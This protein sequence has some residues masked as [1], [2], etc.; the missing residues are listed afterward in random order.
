M[1]EMSNAQKGC[2]MMIGIPLVMLMAVGMFLFFYLPM[3]L[4]IA[5]RSL[6]GGRR[7]S[8]P[9]PRNRPD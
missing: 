8:R 1:R 2:V 9:R 5:V 7:L 3:R 6:F 4:F